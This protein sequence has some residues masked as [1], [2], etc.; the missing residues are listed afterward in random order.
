MLSVWILNAGQGDSIVIRFPDNSWGVVDS[1]L[2]LN[3]QVP[4]ALSFL[5]E[6]GV[7]KLAFVCLTHPHSD[8]FSGLGKV[9]E[10][11]KDHIDEFWIFNVDSAHLRKFLT[12]QHQKNA[13]TPTGW[14]VYSELEGIFRSFSKMDKGGAVVAYWAA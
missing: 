7:Q 2:A 11:Y 4:P 3:S 9:L 1:N 8:H 13:T 6:R 12:A 10:S 5:Q 14:A